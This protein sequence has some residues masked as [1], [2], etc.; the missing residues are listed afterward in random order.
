MQD[1][2][3]V[4][5]PT[6]EAKVKESKKPRKTMNGGRKTG[7]VVAGIAGVLALGGTATFLYGLQSDVATMLVTSGALAA[8]QQI[9]TEN[10][11]AVEVDAASVPA[12]ALTMTDI[13]SGR[14]FAKVD[15]TAGTPIIP[16]TV[17]TETRTRVDLPEGVVVASFA[18]DPASA[19][20]GNVRAG[21][22]IDVIAVGS[23]G[24]GN[25]VARVILHRIL[26]LDVTAN[27]NTVSQGGGNVDSNDLAGPNNP[28]VYGGIPS[29]YTVAVT[30]E[31]AAV[32][33]IARSKSLYIVLTTAQAPD[34]LDVQVD[35]TE[36]FGSGSVKANV[37]TPEPTTDGLIDTVTPTNTTP[38][39]P[40]DNSV[41]VP[42]TPTDTTLNR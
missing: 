35:A 42:A 36:V 32:M 1:L 26:V 41:S 14:Y 39:V 6:K 13:A 20:A 24:D 23:N 31:Q 18:A 12:D 40:G 29:L 9:L 25:E 19:V 10:V 21:D 8:N 27:V 28:K 16:A 38:P 5:K 2:T 7:L 30:P 11:N 22:Y 15:L 33:A 4:K 34:S 3:D 37:I 17:D